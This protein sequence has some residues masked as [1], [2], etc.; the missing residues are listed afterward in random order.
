MQE[1]ARAACILFDVSPKKQAAKAQAARVAYN[2]GLPD[3]VCLPY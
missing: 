1:G 2:S 3:Q